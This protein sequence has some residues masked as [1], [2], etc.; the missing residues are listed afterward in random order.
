MPPDCLRTAPLLQQQQR[1]KMRHWPE[2]AL[3]THVS[4]CSPRPP[5]PCGDLAATYHGQGGGVLVGVDAV[6]SGLHSGAQRVAVRDL[7]VWHRECAVC[8]KQGMLPL[9]PLP[10]TTASSLHQP[11]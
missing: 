6:A 3:V 2:V 5:Q 1:E 8:S 10:T 7:A 11:M 4:Q 9:R